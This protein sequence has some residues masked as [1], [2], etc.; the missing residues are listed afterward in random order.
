M[1]L[2]FVAAVLLCAVLGVVASPTAAQT[3]SLDQLLEQV[4][5]GRTKDIEENAARLRT[6][7][8]NEAQQASL[9]EQAK[10]QQEQ[11][12]AR[13][14]RL[15]EEFN[16]NEVELRQEEDKLK[17][18][19][20]TLQELFG[21]LQQ[22]AGDARAQFQDSLT[23]VQFPE[24][25]EFLTTLARKMGQTRGLPEMEEIERLWFEFQREMIE[26]GKVVRYPARVVNASG[27]ET[28]QEV[29]RV[30]LFN[31]VANGR[32]LEYVPETGRLVELS[33][34]PGGRF[35][36]AIEELE[37]SSDGLVAFGL[38][39]A[40][41]GSLS[42]LVQAPSL[43]ER[44]RQGGVVAYIIIALGFIA[45]L[46]A[47]ERL[48]VLSLT[49]SKVRRQAR[50]PARPGGNPLG[51]VLQVYHQN[52]EV[53][54]ET[55]ELKL[56][57]A[58]LKETPAFNRML[59]FLKVIAVVAPLL[60]LLGTVTGMILTFQ[61][62]TLFGTGDPRLM[63]GGISQALV[64]TVLGLCVAIPIVLLHAVVAG[65]ARQL[66]ELLEEQATGMVAEQAEQRHT[67]HAVQ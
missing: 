7:K 31:V 11:E 16:N 44:V 51:R 66:T 60:G 47:V 33:R 30:G 5:K 56:A 1:I 46:V 39:P 19:L 36:R 53:D 14:Q 59:M 58:V 63:A 32:Y 29:T 62:I 55:L 13:S 28:E 57:E 15:E 3:L 52:R 17:E 2:R 49:M 64:T 61:A 35:L 10:A 48:I 37:N 18:R 54:T 45:L 22:S 34:Q 38:D 12:E 67:L 27:E 26:S 24:R 25:T 6:F 42:A 4:K 9:L 50:D 43:R 21:V 20:G 23:H 65:K 8:E 41:G 40:R